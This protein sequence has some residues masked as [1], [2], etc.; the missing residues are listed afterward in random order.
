[1]SGNSYK[2]IYA[3]SKEF[4]FKIGAVCCPAFNNELIYFNR[5]GFKH[6]IR[7]GTR[8]RDSAEIMRRLRLFPYAVQTVRRA[9]KIYSYKVI[10]RQQSTAHFW[11]LREILHSQSRRIVIRVIIRKLNNGHIHF[12][13]VFDE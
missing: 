6:L 3:E 5:Q 11:I 9:E 12:F 8:R 10:T 2:K 13:S 4:Y 1:M 7:K